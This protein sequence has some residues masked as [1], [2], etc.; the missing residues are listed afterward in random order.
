MAT[1]RLRMREPHE[2]VTEPPQP[3]VLEPGT[4]DTQRAVFETDKVIGRNQLTKKLGTAFILVMN[5]FENL[6]LMY[7]VLLVV[8]VRV[9]F[10]R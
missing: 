2:P 7:H 3:G 6:C 1:T 8:S 10:L 5:V 4:I 9:S